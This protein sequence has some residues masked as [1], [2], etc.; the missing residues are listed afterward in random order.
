MSTADKGAP[1]LIDCEMAVRALYDYLDGR[2]PDATTS[3]VEGHLATCRGCASHFTFARRLLELVP[4]S[5]PLAGEASV[6]RARV[7]ESLKAEGYSRS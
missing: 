5:L 6:L 3:A 7:V 2:L 1:A 4:S